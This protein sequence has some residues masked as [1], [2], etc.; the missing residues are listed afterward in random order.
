[1]NVINVNTVNLLTISQYSESGVT[2]YYNFNQT[3]IKLTRTFDP[4]LLCQHT[5]SL[6]HIQYTDNQIPFDLTVCG[7]DSTCSAGMLLQICV[8]AG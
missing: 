1:M 5:F 6:T 4:M 8:V 7:I 2:I 3:L